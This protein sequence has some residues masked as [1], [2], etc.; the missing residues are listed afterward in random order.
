MK[1]YAVS[2]K[3]IKNNKVRCDVNGGAGKGGTAERFGPP[4]N[5]FVSFFFQEK[6][7]EG[8]KNYCMPPLL[9]YVLL[10]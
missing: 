7:E 6:K 3:G 10:A 1:E 9:L 4:L 8:N 5:F 2:R